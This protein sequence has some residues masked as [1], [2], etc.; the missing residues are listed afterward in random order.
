MFPVIIEI[1]FQSE[2]L[3][4]KLMTMF[5]LGLQTDTQGLWTTDVAL[6]RGPELSEHSVAVNVAVPLWLSPCGCHSGCHPVA[7]TL[8]LSLCDYYSGCPF[9]HKDTSHVGL[10]LQS[11]DFQIRSHRYL[12]LG[13]QHV[14]FGDTIRSTTMS[15]ELAP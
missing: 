7:V 1:I 4:A 2:S 13:L 9:F 14:I 3:L 10:Y 11:S 5:L 6:A 12:E 15:S 8:W